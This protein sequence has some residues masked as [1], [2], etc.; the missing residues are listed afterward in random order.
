MRIHDYESMGVASLRVLSAPPVLEAYRGTD[1]VQWYGS[2]EGQLGRKE[3]EYRAV[4]NNVYA[5]R[6]HTFLQTWRDYELTGSVN[7][8]DV[9]VLEAAAAQNAVDVWQ[10]QD[11]F[12]NLRDSLR[13]LKASLEELPTT[14]AT[15]QRRRLSPKGGPTGIPTPTKTPTPDEAPPSQGDVAETPPPEQ[16]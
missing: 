2:I 5:D 4:K 7:V 3:A 12:R 11:Y 14:G 10:M 16:V 8:E 13:R 15:P 9:D 6:I 1:I